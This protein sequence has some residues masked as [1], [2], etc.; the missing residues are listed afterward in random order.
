MA[1]Q[2]LKKAIEIARSIEND[3]VCIYSFTQIYGEMITPKKFIN[4]LEKCISLIE[5]V[6]G[7]RLYER[8]DS[9]I[10]PHQGNLSSMTLT[11]NF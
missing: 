5:R 6:A 2:T 3:D 10:I 8:P 1:M 9:E 11:L 4:H 7:P